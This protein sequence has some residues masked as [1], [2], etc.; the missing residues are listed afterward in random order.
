[1][2]TCELQTRKLTCNR[3]ITT[4]KTINMWPT[5][6]SYNTVVAKGLGPLIKS[7]SPT[8]ASSFNTPKIK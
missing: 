6:I 5:L 4:L 3:T 8:F 1:M 2:N 7:E